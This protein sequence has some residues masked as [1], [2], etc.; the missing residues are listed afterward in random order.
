MTEDC[1]YILK[2]ILP[3]LIPCIL[4]TSCF[5]DEVPVNY[6]FEDAEPY[7]FKI[8]IDNSVD[9]P[10]QIKTENL[11]GWYKQEAVTFDVTDGEIFKVINEKNKLSIESFPSG[12]SG[13]VIFTILCGEKELQLDEYLIVLGA[14]FTE[15]KRY[16]YYATDADPYMNVTNTVIVLEISM[17]DGAL[18]YTW[19][20]E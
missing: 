15:K 2:K 8:S 7:Y 4:F 6:K 12:Y 19:T 17:E 14:Y 11:Y 5:M 9:A 13:K 20:P 3:L 1:L 18:K 16:G 10:V